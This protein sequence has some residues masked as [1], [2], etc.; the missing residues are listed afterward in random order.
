MCDIGVCCNLLGLLK[1][2]E[3]FQ[4]DHSRE[5]AVDLQDRGMWQGG[6]TPLLKD[7]DFGWVDGVM[8]SIFLQLRCRC[9]MITYTNKVMQVLCHSI[10]HNTN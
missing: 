8:V 2:Q 10:R 4:K 5:M 7:S 6:K 1:N 9:S 3:F